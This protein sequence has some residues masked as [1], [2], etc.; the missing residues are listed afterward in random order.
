MTWAVRPLHALHVL[1][2]KTPTSLPR[3]LRRIWIGKNLEQNALM[4]MLKSANNIVL[5]EPLPYIRFM[6]PES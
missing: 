3:S 1:H 2:G 6:N 4:P 5:A